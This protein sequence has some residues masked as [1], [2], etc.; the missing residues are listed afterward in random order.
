MKGKIR[1]LYVSAKKQ[2]AGVGFQCPSCGCKDSAIVSRKYLVTS[3]RRCR[4]CYLLFRAPT[5]SEEESLLFYQK[6]YSQGF[7]TDCPSHELLQKYLKRGFAGTEKDYKK[8]IEVIF[9]AGGKKGDKLFDFG[10]SW[11]YGSWQFLQEGFRVVAYEISVPRANY[12]RANLG[13]ETCLSL[14]DVPDATFDIFFSAH[15]LEHVSCVKKV[16][17][18]G[19][20]ILKP[21]GLFVA[22][23]PNGSEAHKRRNKEGWKK[24]WGMVHPNFLDDKYYK[25]QFFSKKHLVMSSPYD[26]SL[27]KNWSEDKFIGVSSK[28]DGEELLVLVKK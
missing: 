7:T 10:C 20:R 4:E 25:K 26:L 14:T 8:Y 19:M 23:T 9:A 15:V 12:A 13:I 3:L 28:L 5:T 6:D 2:L 27:I 11:G 24:L 1:Y 17:D 21:N 18:F 16:I 22:F